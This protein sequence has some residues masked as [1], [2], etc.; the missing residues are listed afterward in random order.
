MLFGEKKQYMGS[1]FS[2]VGFGSSRLKLVRDGGILGMK[3][4][5]FS[6]FGGSSLLKRQ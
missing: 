4:S 2:F 1:S 5:G 6:F 3:L